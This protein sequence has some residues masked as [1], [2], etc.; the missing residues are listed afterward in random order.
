M[1]PL[2]PK[3]GT[4]PRLNQSS[5][6]YTIMNIEMFK[7][8]FK[9][10]NVEIIQDI[11]KPEI[12]QLAIDQTIT[13]KE[14]DEFSKTNKLVLNY[15][16]PFQRAN[17]SHWLIVKFHKQNDEDRENAIKAARS[18]LSEA[19]YCVDSLWCDED[20]LHRFKLSREEAQGLVQDVLSSDRI[21]TEINEAIEDTGRM[22]KFSPRLSDEEWMDE[23][24]PIED[25]G[26]GRPKDWG[27]D[28]PEL[29][30]LDKEH[31][32]WTLVEVDEV[33][34]ILNGMHKDNRLEYWVTEN[35]YN[36]GENIEVL[37]YQPEEV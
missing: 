23:Y 31:R 20:A 6:K 15:I 4:A 21:M 30:A 14:I 7:T 25:D 3:R 35:S 2:W 9:P 19:G 10:K 13:Q 11:E 37:W 24:L 34:Y 12:V 8:E 16:S 29:E 5:T 33:Q 22:E 1:R 32:V 28:N 18:C 17:G 36:E 27:F 26:D